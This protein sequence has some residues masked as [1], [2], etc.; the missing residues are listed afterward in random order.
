MLFIYYEKDLNNFFPTLKESE[1]LST[2][3]KAIIGKMM[4][5][6]IASIVKNIQENQKALKNNF[7]KKIHA[8]IE[9]NQSLQQTITELKKDNNNP[10]INVVKSLFFKHLDNNNCTITL[11]NES[12]KKLNTLSTNYKLLDKTIENA[13]QFI[14][15]TNNQEIPSHLIVD[16]YLINIKYIENNETES[17]QNRYSRTIKLLNNLEEAVQIALENNLSP[18]GINVGKS[19]KKPISAPAISDALK[20][21]RSKILTLLEKHPQE[22]PYL[23]QYFKPL[24]NME[25]SK[26]EIYAKQ[27]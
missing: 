4:F 18:T 3:L 11:T 14:K 2:Q 13:V 15:T 25:L 21:H 9:A 16:S 8:L 5:N 27:A 6:N 22:W 7:N 19:M 23:R 10:F 17:L 26:K 1:T 20:K 24:Q 12:L